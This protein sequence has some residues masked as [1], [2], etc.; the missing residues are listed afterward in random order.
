MTNEDKTVCPHC[1]SKLTPWAPPDDSSWGSHAQ[2]VCFNDECPYYVRGW[3]WMW[4]R[5]QQKASYRWRFNPETK[6]QGP[7]P[8]WSDV[9]LRDGIV[10]EGW[11]P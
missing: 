6:E 4:E 8:V 3:Q 1:G 5:Y 9:A 10:E 2:W 7:L 11:T